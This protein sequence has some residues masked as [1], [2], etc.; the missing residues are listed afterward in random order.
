MKVLH[1]VPYLPK[2]SGVTTFVDEVS[3]Q[4]VAN[5]VG[6]AVCVETVDCFGMTKVEGVPRLSVSEA[7]K[8]IGDFDIIHIHG[9][10]RPCMHKFV[11]AA[12]KFKKPIV[13]SLHG[14]LSPWAMKF[15]RWKKLPV[16]WLW[17]KRDLK[18]A[19]VLHVTSEI[20]KVW[21]VSCGFT[22]RI[23]EVPLG[24][25]ISEKECLRNHSRKTLL[26]VGRINP[27]KGL[28]NLIR[29]WS[30]C[31]EIA[32][33]NDWQ[34]RLV[35]ICGSDYQK[36]LQMLASSFGAGSNVSFP[37]PKYDEELMAEYG[38]ADALVLPSFTENF[39]GVVVDAMA[40]GLPV[41]T[42]R[43]T[44]WRIVEERRCG[45][46][47]DNRPESLSRVIQELIAMPERER[48][49]MG[50]RARQLAVEKYSWTAVARSVASIYASVFEN[51]TSVRENES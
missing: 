31:F 40:V 27:I 11:V 50:S 33:K 37:G 41:I 28:E 13:W 3:K 14:M 45:W 38:N 4:L 47:V 26:F 48:C 21:V 35:G 36:K 8:Q 9:I 25:S 44:P 34:L 10:W 16:W 20:E 42:S 7:L 6:C 49:S 39:G 5:G 23:E 19:A 43:G 22:N 29:A 1:I 51:K 46:W 18:H 32:V 2:A 17:Q 24:V 15:K 12:R 30:D